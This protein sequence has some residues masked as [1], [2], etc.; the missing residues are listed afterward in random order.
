MHIFTCYYT[1]L[2][3]S[4]YQLTYIETQGLDFDIKTSFP[5]TYEAEK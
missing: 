3:I 5:F 4:Q 2:T 1:I